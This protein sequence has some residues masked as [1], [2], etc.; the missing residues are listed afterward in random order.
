MGAQKSFLPRRSVGRS[1]GRKERAV[2]RLRP[3][4]PSSIPP[5]KGEEGTAEEEEQNRM[6]DKMEE[7]RGNLN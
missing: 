2:F 5:P 6:D 1:E 7:E 3:L 4:P